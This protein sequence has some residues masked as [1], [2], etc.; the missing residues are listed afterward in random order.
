MSAS[1]IKNS[2]KNRLT[3]F[4]ITNAIKSYISK[5]NLQI[6]DGIHNFGITKYWKNKVC[7]ECDAV[8]N[9]SNE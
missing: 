1:I 6:M 9:C 8:T 2:L 4:I 5:E 7:Q 3:E